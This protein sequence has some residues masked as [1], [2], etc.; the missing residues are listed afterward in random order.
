M[1]HSGPVTIEPPPGKAG[2]GLVFTYANGVKM[3]HGG[4]GGCTFEGTEGTLVVTRGS[5][6]STPESIL[7][8]PIGG[9]DVRVYRS[10]NHVA[11][12]LE[13]VRSRKLPICDVEIGHRS[14]S[15]CQLG[16]IGYELRRPLTWDPEKE[17]F[18]DDPEAN[19]LTD[20]KIR[21]PSK[22]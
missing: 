17:R 9:D 3:I 10:V 8:K 16:A 20:R 4:I 15:I 22:L 1:D 5:I 7:T 13:C 11:N 14:A 18:K 19:K 6:K 21:A 12:W 2:K